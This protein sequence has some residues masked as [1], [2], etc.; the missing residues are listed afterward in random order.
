MTRVEVRL[1]ATLRRYVPTLDIGDPLEVELA[2]G[3]D[4][5]DLFAHLG[6]PPDEVKQVFINHRAVRKNCVLENGDRVSLFPPVAGG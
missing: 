5:L 6:I 1:Y 3:G 4:L 2:P